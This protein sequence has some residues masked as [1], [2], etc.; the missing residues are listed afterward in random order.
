MVLSVPW[1]TPFFRLLVKEQYEVSAIFSVEFLPW[2]AERRSVTSH[3]TSRASSITHEKKSIL[4]DKTGHSEGVNDISPQGP[5][6]HYKGTLYQ[7]LA[8]SFPI[9]LSYPFSFRGFD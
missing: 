5:K 2:I 4:K 1:D 3:Y 6:E 7:V 8:S 9:G